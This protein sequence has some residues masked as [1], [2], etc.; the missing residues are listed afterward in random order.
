MRMSTLPA[1]CRNL[2]TS[3]HTYYNVH[4]N[5]VIIEFYGCLLTNGVIID[6]TTD[7]VLKTDDISTIIPH[8]AGFIPDVKSESNDLV[9]VITILA[10]TTV[11]LCTDVVLTILW[12]IRKRTLARQRLN[13][14]GEFNARKLCDIIKSY[15][16]CALD[17]FHTLALAMRRNQCDKIASG[18]ADSHSGSVGSRRVTTLC[19]RGM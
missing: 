6:R 11:S 1:P 16:D 8:T 4:C 19:Q 10:V 3:L 5:W 15:R 13:K 9:I 17:I 7:Q 2:F 18:L 14:R 12:S